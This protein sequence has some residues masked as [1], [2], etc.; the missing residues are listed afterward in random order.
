M[1][2]PRRINLRIPAGIDTGA[3]LRVQGEG[4]HGQREDLLVTS[5]LP[6]WSNPIQN[7]NGMVIP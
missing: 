1:R 2:K 4:E 7:F 5:I 3:R 6:L